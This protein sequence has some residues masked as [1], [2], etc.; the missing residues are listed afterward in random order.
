M[1]LP[2]L[3][4]FAVL[5]HAPD[6]VTLIQPKVKDSYVAALLSA[7]GEAFGLSYR[8]LLGG[9]V[10][11]ILVLLVENRIA[12]WFKLLLA[13]VAS[14]VVFVAALS[15]AAGILQQQPIKEAGLVAREVKEPLVMWRLNTP[16]FNVYSQ[17]STAK[18]D[19]RA[20][21]VVLTKTRHLPELPAY[22]LLYER[23]GV[24][25]ARVL[26]AGSGK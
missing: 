19:P 11:L 14:A 22:E 25:L 23:R 5:F 20:G 10:A 12:S 4:F 15:P 24:A 13:G 21:E 16:S 26:P 2:A 7:P 1:L 17:K 6:I 9:A 18:R 8:L 3:L